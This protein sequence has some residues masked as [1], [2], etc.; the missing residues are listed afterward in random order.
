MTEG[1]LGLVLSGGGARGA[2]EAGV[3]HYIFSELAKEYH[4]TPQIRLVSGTSVGAVNGTFIASALMREDAGTE[5]L[6]AVWEGLEL[7]NIL[8]FGFKQAAGLYR[9]LLGG[10]EARGI[11]DASPLSAVV[12]RSIKWR[13]LRQNIRTGRLKALTVSTTNVST[14]H[15]VIFVDAAPGVGIPQSLGIHALVRRARIGQHHVLA[16]GAIP[17]I[18]PPVQIGD[19]IHCD[20]GLRLNT[21]MAP[22]IHLGMDRLLVVG[23][24]TQHPPEESP[25]REGHYPGATFLLG[26]VL[27]AFLLDHVNTDLLEVERI[28]SFLRDGEAAF[29][30]DFLERLNAAA[31]ARGALAPRRVVQALVLRPSIDIGRLAAEYL[32]SNR[33]RFG[34]ILGRAFLSL[35]DVGEGADADL[36]S[37]LLFDGGFAKHLIEVGRKD[38]RDRKDELAGFLFDA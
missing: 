34:K 16:S 18:F 20:G 2:Y 10:T 9:V 33:A 7:Q 15:P 4:T 5:E 26:K 21:P 25:L 37:Y 1:G 30:P 6:V 38:A 36:A 32:A 23:L 3:L 13:K 11:F 19:E 14:G 27:N 12:G 17:L 29:G 8:G 31:K 22:S 28:N 24:S 35:L